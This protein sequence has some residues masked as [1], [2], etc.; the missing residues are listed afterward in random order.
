MIVWGFVVFVF[1]SVLGVVGGVEIES[2][3]QNKTSKQK[4]IELNLAHYNQKTGKFVQDSLSCA[5][6]SCVI[7]RKNGE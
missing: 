2:S 1:G 5:N 4:M 7:I 6:D 3:T